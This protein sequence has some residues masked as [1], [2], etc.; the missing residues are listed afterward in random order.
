MSDAEASVS[1]SSSWAS[2]PSSWPILR[3][4]RSFREGD[5]AARVQL[6]PGDELGDKIGAK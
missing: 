3:T 5:Y 2:V 1:A 4:L 6:R